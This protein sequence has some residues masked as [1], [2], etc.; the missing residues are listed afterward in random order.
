MID[1]DTA[2]NDHFAVGDTIGVAANGPERSGSRSSASRSTATSSRSAARR[3]RV[4]TIPTRAEA[5][6]ASTATRAISVAAKSGVSQDELAGELRRSLPGD[7]RRCKTADEQASADKKAIAGFLTF[8]RGFLLGFGGIALFVGAFV[9]FNTLSITVAQRTRELAT[10]RT[11]GATRRQV[12]RSVILESAALGAARVGRRPVRRLRPRQGPQLALQR[13]R[14]R[15]AGGGAGLRAAHVRRVAARSASSSPCSPGIVPAVRATKVRADRGRARRAAGAG[16]QPSRR[17]SSASRCSSLAA[18]LLGYAVTGDRLGS[19]SSLL[20]LAFGAL[21]LISRH[22]RR[23]VAARRR[24]R[25]GARLALARFGGAAGRARVGERGAQPAAHGIHGRG[26]DDR[27]RARL[28][29]RRA[30][31]GRARLDEQRDHG[32]VPGAVDRHVEERLVGLPDRRRRRRREGAGR[33]AGR[34]DPRR[35]R[36]DRQDAGERRRRRSGDDRRALPLRVEAR[37]VRRRRSRS[38]AGGGAIVKES[39]AKKNGLA[40]R[41][42]VRAARRRRGDPVSLARRRLLPAAAHRRAA[43]RRRSSARARSTRRSR[44][45]R[46]RSR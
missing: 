11:L 7:R 13:A 16:A 31:Q 28:V 45:R 5:A 46:T 10:L 9:I 1:P 21:A 39:F 44:G 14:P 35:P 22:G 17:R 18:L 25:G 36:A 3:S 2:K 37:L 15:P 29:R 23:R 19:G 8:I 34:V 6:A 24:A 33:D 41:R 12:L 4:F 40:A 20:A 32:A 26:A 30:R 27:H 38:S 43:R 42:P